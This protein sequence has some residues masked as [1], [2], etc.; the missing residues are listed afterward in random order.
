MG[1]L[2]AERLSRG[3]SEGLTFLVVTMTV[4]RVVR[5]MGPAASLAQLAKLLSARLL[6]D[7]RRL[8]L[9]RRA[10]FGLTLP[11]FTGCSSL[12]LGL[13]FLVVFLEHDA[14]DVL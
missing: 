1:L 10:L 11:V 12:D 14:L 8:A 13:E 6:R 4:A 3:I 2:C 5:L 7:S 9:L